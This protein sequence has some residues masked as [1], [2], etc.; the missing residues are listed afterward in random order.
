MKRHQL[1]N[2]FHVEAPRDGHFTKPKRFVALEDGSVLALMADATDSR[3]CIFMTSPTRCG[4]WYSGA[5]RIPA[6]IEVLW[7]ELVEEH[8][9]QAK[10]KLVN[11]LLLQPTST[12]GRARVAAAMELSR[13]ALADD[14]VAEGCTAYA[15]Q[16]CDSHTPEEIEAQYRAELKAYDERR[17]ANGS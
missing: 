7:N 16:F 13:L 1:L 2:G 8:L 9:G 15:E 3:F 17:R 6:A 5:L 11:R 4:I 10:E 12:N 14:E